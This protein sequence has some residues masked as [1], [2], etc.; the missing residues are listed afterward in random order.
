MKL[1]NPSPSRGRFLVAIITMCLTN[2][3]F[4]QSADP[5][6]HETIERRALK[7]TPA[8][9]DATATAH[10]LVPVLQIAEQLY[11]HM[12]REIH[13]Y[14]CVLVK[15]ERI[16]GELRPSEHVAVKFR[17]HLNNDDSADP[18]SVYARV[19]APKSIVGREV[20]YVDGENDGEMLVTRGGR[21]NATMTFSIR[22]QGRMAAKDNKYP[23]TE[24]GMENLL[25][26]I[27][28]VAK[29]DMK[30]DE[31]YVRSIPNTKVDG[32]LCT[33]FEVKH[34]HPRRHFL[35]HLARIFVDDELRGPV[36]FAAYTWP[37][38]EGGDPV[39]VEEYTFRNIRFNVGLNDRDF[40][41]DHPDY[42]FRPVD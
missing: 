41:Y 2:S 28:E 19:L 14:T 39:L 25:A 4:A 23:I 22:P 12:N 37:E 9:L 16:D 20:L 18:F 33:M 31:C 36:R 30:F 3:G 7:V 15:R 8:S 11:E 6:V 10:P 42:K 13:D 26:R 17:G 40:A 5:A 32:R 29:Q 27:M 21:R 35:Y 1:L 24:F 38:T 34:P